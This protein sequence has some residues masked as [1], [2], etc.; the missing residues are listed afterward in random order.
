MEVGDMI[1]DQS[2]AYEAENGAGVKPEASQKIKEKEK[3]TSEV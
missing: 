1:V 3:E 2:M